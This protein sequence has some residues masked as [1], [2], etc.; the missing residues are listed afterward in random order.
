MTRE[1]ALNPRVIENGCHKILANQ[2][3][4][5]KKTEIEYFYLQKLQ[6]LKKPQHTD[7]IHHKK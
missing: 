1:S 4:I 7:V 2:N 6:K 5:F 3:L